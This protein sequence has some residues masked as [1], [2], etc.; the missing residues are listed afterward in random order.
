MW[1][2]P[3]NHG[4]RYAKSMIHHELNHN[5][6]FENLELKCKNINAQI[7]RMQNRTDRVVCFQNTRITS[8]EDYHHIRVE[9]ITQSLQSPCQLYGMT[10]LYAQTFKIL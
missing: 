4:K 8:A 6:S 10:W 1:C 5:V 3:L 9:T 7:R 2:I